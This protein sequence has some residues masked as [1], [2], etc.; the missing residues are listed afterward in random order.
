MYKLK[1]SKMIE[2]EEN[3]NEMTE[4]RLVLEEVENR[5]MP[6]AYGL[7]PVAMN[8]CTTCCSGCGCGRAQAEL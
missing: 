3:Q 2:S 5:N 7:A 4:V 6:S 1:I 8:T